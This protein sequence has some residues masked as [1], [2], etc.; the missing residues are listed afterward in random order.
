MLSRYVIRN[1]KAVIAVTPARDG[2]QKAH[3]Y[4]KTCYRSSSVSLIGIRCT[5]CDDLQ[6]V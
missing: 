3:T 4:D 1:E 2:E 6:V 5:D